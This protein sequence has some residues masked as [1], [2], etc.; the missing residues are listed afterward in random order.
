MNNRILKGVTAGMLAAAMLSACGGGSGSTPPVKNGGGTSSQ[1]TNVT[2]TFAVPAKRTSSVKRAVLRKRAVDTISPSTKALGIN[3]V[4]HGAN[5]PGLRTPQFAANIAAGTNAN[6]VNCTAAAGDGS[7]NCTLLIAA[8]VGY[9]DIEVTAWDGTVDA[10]PGPGFGGTF[11]GTQNLLAIGF[12]KNQ[13][14]QLNQQNVFGIP[15]SSVVYSA[16][17]NVLPNSLV[18]GA[19]TGSGTNPTNPTVV[20]YAKDADGNI[21]PATNVNPYYDASGNPVTFTVTANPVAMTLFPSDV[22]T[23]QFGCPGTC[24]SSATFAHPNDTATITYNG[25]PIADSGLALTSTPACS[26]LPCSSGGVYTG[27]LVNAT[28]SFTQS[29]GTGT[30]FP[31][32]PEIQTIAALN[33][34]SGIFNGVG[35]SPDGTKMWYTEGNSGIVVQYDPNGGGTVALTVPN[36]RNPKQIM[37]GSDGD[38]WFITEGNPAYFDRIDLAHGTPTNSSIAEMAS[39]AST[40][41]WFTLGSDGNIYAS[42][43]GTNQ[44]L[45]LNIRTLAQTTCS[46]TGG[47]P[48]YV[49]VAPDGTVW[50]TQG[51]SSS[52]IGKFS[53]PGGACTQYTPAFTGTRIEGIASGPDGNLW[54]VEQSGGSNFTLHPSPDGGSI[55]A[56]VSTSGALVA[57]CPSGMLAGEYTGITQGPD[58]N[59]YLAGNDGIARVTVNA[60]APSSCS[61]LEF[62]AVT[63]SGSI[64]GTGIAQ[65]LLGPSNG[66]GGLTAGTPNGALWFMTEA[67]SLNNGTFGVV[68]P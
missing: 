44:I 16:D 60:A 22:G 62:T 67:G 13:L 21:I 38:E 61:A 23:T 4:A 49:G 43:S 63:P 47:S 1:K 35:V 50:Y 59:M 52:A 33:A 20:V 34:N 26:A 39:V 6:N 10:S 32:T 29:P 41:G 8:P 18:A 36:S 17:V 53:N 24:S 28:L 55:I 15:M 12:D 37:A 48:N 65:L 11:G 7:Y 51:S 56:K 66:A 5:F 57:Q 30:S 14:V 25:A 40:T 27:N 19:A 31:G 54:V 2:L 64:A 45:Q 58:G 46:T 42:L 68:T 9:D 3:V